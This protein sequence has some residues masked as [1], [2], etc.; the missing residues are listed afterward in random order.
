MNIIQRKLEAFKNIGYTK[1]KRVDIMRV[2]I[3]RYLVLT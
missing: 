2:K 3:K 1:M